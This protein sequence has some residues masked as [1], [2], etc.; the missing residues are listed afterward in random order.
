MHQTPA[1]SPTNADSLTWRVS[2]SEAVTDID[3]ADFSVSGAGLTTPTLSVAQDGNTNAWDVSVSGGNLNNYNGTITLSL[4]SA[5]DITDIA[6]NALTST[7]PGDASNTWVLDNTAPTVLDASV[8]GAT[9][10]VTFSKTMA[11]TKAA[12]VRL[13]GERGRQ[14]AQRQQLHPVGRHRQPH[15]DQCR[16]RQ[17][18]R[19]PR[20]HPTGRQ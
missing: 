1:T 18:G 10:T 9:L 20:L 15:P 7:L 17:P 5:Q 11:D 3:N 19:H 4:A 12:N 16:H 2:F 6:G 8:N 14:L 13:G